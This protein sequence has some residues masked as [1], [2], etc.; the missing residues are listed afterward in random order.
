MICLADILCSMARQRGG[1]GRSISL[2]LHGAYSDLY[3][4]S[5]S[6]LYGI[7]QLSRGDAM[8]C[9]V[10]SVIVSPED[11]RTLYAAAGP[12]VYALNARVRTVN[13]MRG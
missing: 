8:A 12:C 4:R 13:C 7:S 2:A 1:T 11:P 10:S 5:R 9:R 3:G 6:D